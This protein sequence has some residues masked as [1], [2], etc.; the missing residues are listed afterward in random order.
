MQ[1]SEKTAVSPQREVD[2][3]LARGIAKA[4]WSI[5]WERV[6]PPLAAFLTV[7]GLF[8]ALS[9]LG[10]WLWLPPLA[11]AVGVVIFGLLAL[12][13]LSP[14]AMIRMPS[15]SEGLRRLDRESGL[16]HRPAITLTD[17]LSAHGGDA[18]TQALWRVHVERALAAARKLRAGWPMPH[19]SARDPVA[20]RGACA[21]AG[22]CDLLR[23]RR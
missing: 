2:R 1:G 4:R 21:G 19:L 7:G 16:P 11:R 9:W 20:I 5:L 15:A 18:M 13:A 22:G 6:W 12:A 3:L 10:L 14:F 8:L 23:R 17:R